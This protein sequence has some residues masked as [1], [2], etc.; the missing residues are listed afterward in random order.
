MRV[1]IV[2]KTFVSD[3]YQR[4]LEWI[5]R[6]PDVDLALITPPVWRSDDGRLLPF[7]SRYTEGYTVR[8]LPIRFNGHFHLY[9]YRGL[10]RTLRS[11]RPDVVHIDEE[12]YNPAG[13]QAQWAADSVGARTVF[14]VLQ[15]LRRRYPPPYSLFEQYNYRHTAHIIAV[16]APAGD[17]VRAKGYRGPLS[18]FSVYGI[19][20][21]LYVPTP[22]SP[23]GGTF[24]VGYIGRIVIPKGLGVLIE[25]LSQLPEI[26]RLRLVGSG[27][28]AETLKRLAAERGVAERVTFV[29]AVQT[30]EVP[31]ELSRMDV[32]V[33]P[34]LSRRNWTEQ[35]GR[36]L[37]EAMAC[38]V[39]VVG[40]DSGEIPR[41]IGDAGLIV[42]EGD[43][44]ALRA[45]LLRLY[46][47]PDERS[48]LARRG[49]ER[50]LANFT[51][52]QVALK[53]V[54][55]WRQALARQLQIASLH[56]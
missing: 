40:S 1:V 52:E 8:P 48:D 46:E 45:A 38:Q 7:V 44:S 34:S 16:N 11:I 41:V 21:D 27:S 24:V 37:I 29:P 36:V 35:F 26:Y 9:T 25:V 39:P 18:A 10:L 22:H 42:P 12:P 43:V 33:L 15:N 2:S 20:P 53:T 4:Q 54:G 23:H 31:G 28:D 49:R 6:Q 55:V 51:Q 32:L 3:T 50:V 13:T 47:R 17:V 5:A 56:S 14:V 30:S 19:D